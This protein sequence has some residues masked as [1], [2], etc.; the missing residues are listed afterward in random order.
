MA[1]K[2]SKT[3]R[4]RIVGVITT[5]EELR[6]AS[7]MVA[8]PDFFELRLDRLSGL[9]DEIEKVISRLRAPIIITARHPREGGARNL[10]IGRRRD[11]LLRFLPRARYIDVELRS[12]QELKEVLELAQKKKVRLILSFH[13][14]RTTPAPGAL[15]AKARTAKSF[16][17]DIL[18]IAT[19]TDTPAQLAR[20]LEFVDKQDARVGIS[21][22]GIGKLGAVSRAA[23]A[24][25]GSSLIYA[26]I[27][28]AR[29]EGQPS[30]AQLRATLKA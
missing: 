15:H 13:D 27:G 19:R 28:P 21:A 2:S 7:R 9:E 12:A 22:M 5:A 3:R 1:K 26:S 4:G 30:L 24:R 11:L 29:I 10:P 6:Q 20:L 8:P 16:G 25:C 18:K 14:L 23:L 17:A